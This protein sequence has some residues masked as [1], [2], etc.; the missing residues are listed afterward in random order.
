MEI[1]YFA[2]ENWR[3][4]FEHAKRHKEQTGTP[5]HKEPINLPPIRYMGEDVELVPGDPGMRLLHSITIKPKVC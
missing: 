1:C 5:P 4:F 3:M 2:A